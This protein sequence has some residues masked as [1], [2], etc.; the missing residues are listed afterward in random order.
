MSVRH[1]Y[2]NLVKRLCKQTLNWLQDI[3]TDRKTILARA[4]LMRGRPNFPIYFKHTH[5]MMLSFS[6]FTVCTK[7]AIFLMS[8][9]G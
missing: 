4:G 8:L 2:E 7:T 6:F 5:Q 1:F 3:A 9:D